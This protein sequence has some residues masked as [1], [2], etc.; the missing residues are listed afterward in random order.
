MI[1]AEFRYRQDGGLTM[2]IRGHAMTAAPGKDLVCGAVSALADT[3]AAAAAYLESMGMLSRKPWMEFGK[4]EA[5][6]SLMPKS[7]ARAEACLVFWTIQVGISE[8]AKTYPEAVAL[9][10]VLH[11]RKGDMEKL[12]QEGEAWKKIR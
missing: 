8:L 7:W 10:G 4:G 1:H 5:F 11:I 3:A 6:L 12:F 9:D 2:K